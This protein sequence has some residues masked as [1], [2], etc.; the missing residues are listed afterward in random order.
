MRRDWDETWRRIVAL[1]GETFYQKRGKPF[2]YKIQYGMLRP[3]T[4]NHQLARSHFEKA[5]ERMPLDGPGGLQDLPRSEL[6][7]GN[8]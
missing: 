1:E 4:T 3:S 8:P 6:P 2:Q 5:F 7:L